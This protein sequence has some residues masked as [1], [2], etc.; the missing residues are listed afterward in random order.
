MCPGVGTT[1]I[2]VPA[3]ASRSP[4]LEH[5]AARARRRRRSAAATWA[6]K[7]APHG[8]AA[9]AWSPWW[10][11]TRTATQRAPRAASTASTAARCAGV[12]RARVDQHRLAAAGVADDV[13]V[14]AVQGH[15]GRVGGEH[16]GD[17]RLELG[18]PR[19]LA[20][21][22]GEGP[23]GARVGRGVHARHASR[24][25]CAG[26]HPAAS[27]ATMRRT[28]SAVPQ[29]PRRR[30]RR[31]PAHRLRRVRTTTTSSSA[32]STSS[33]SARA[34]PRDTAAQADSEFCTRGRG[35]PGADRA[36]RPGGD[37]TRPGTPRRPAL[38]QASAE[39][40]GIEPPAEIADRLGGS[41]PTASS[42]SRG[43]ADVDFN[44]PAAAAQF[45]QTRS[46]S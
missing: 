45:E 15:P 22:R 46:P 42:R 16:A 28:L 36:P 21:G 12:V 34:R 38:Q 37:G 2:V 30:R 13:G 29:R 7:C 1:P 20:P 18:R 39:I 26:A 41:S 10:W 25:A 9:S 31:R 14:G 11:V 27:L 44:D 43:L 17:Q 5:P 40:R 19:Q 32:T 8:S 33:A 6:P 4:V 24:A 35:R 3:R 23:G